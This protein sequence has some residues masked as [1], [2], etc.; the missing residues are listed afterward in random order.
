[1]L[2]PSPV[3]PAGIPSKHVFHG[4]RR[5][6]AVNLMASDVDEQTA[7]S[8]TGH[9]DTKTFR[10]YRVLVEEAKRAAIAKRDATLKKAVVRK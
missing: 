2:A 8:L 9:K 5:S 4:N 10:E 6:P 1:V 3:F 7:M